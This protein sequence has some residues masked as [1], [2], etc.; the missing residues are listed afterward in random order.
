MVLMSAT[1]GAPQLAIAQENSFCLN[2]VTALW[3][4]FSAFSVLAI[5]AITMYWS[6]FSQKEAWE[7]TLFAKD[8]ELR[9]QRITVSFLSRQLTEY[10]EAY[11]K[12]GQSYNAVAEALN[13]SLDEKDA[14]QKLLAE[15]R[16][17]LKSLTEK[18]RI[19]SE[20][21]SKLEQTQKNPF[22]K[23][24]LEQSQEIFRLKKEITAAQKDVA[25]LT[26]K[27]Q[28]LLKRLGGLLQPS[29]SV[30]PTKNTGVGKVEWIRNKDNTRSIACLVID[31][32]K[33]KP[34]FECPN[35]TQELHGYS[36]ARQHVFAKCPK[37][38]LLIAPPKD[39]KRVVG[40]RA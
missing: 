9:T 28:A 36:V 1:A 14:L 8:N 29:M 10:K 11:E 34:I 40:A 15:T 4:A 2:S 24:M 23:Y 33:E 12:L 30:L 21:S 35:C 5:I 39:I 25:D 20:N 17:T 32:K 6:S 7:K 37:K 27:N 18:S 26:R 22:A 16:E 19:I 38:D 3:I 31:D 13:A